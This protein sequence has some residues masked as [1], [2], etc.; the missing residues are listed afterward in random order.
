MTRRVQKRQAE[1]DHLSM[2]WDANKAPPSDLRASKLARQR[3]IGERG[4][5]DVVRGI[6]AFYEATG[7]P[8][9]RDLLRLLE[10]SGL[11]SCRDM[12]K[13][14][15]RVEMLRAQREDLDGLVPQRVA[16]ELERMAQRGERPHLKQACRIVAASMGTDT[17][18]TFDAACKRLEK[19]YRQAARGKSLQMA[20]VESVPGHVDHIRVRPALG[21]TV[22]DPATGS[23]IP[24]TGLLVPNTRYWRKLLDSGAIERLR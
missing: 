2:T 5:N 8:A 7:E 1:I 12:A 24:Q 9:A 10:A 21:R 16:A 6:A 19:T 22:V 17:T 13:F 23:A 11:A 20:A 4:A 14:F 18:G 15:G 3:R